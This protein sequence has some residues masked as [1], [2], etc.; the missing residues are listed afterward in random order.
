MKRERA[1]A[2][3]DTPIPFAVTFINGEPRGCDFVELKLIQIFYFVFKTNMQKS[4]VV[5]IDV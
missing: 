4:Q 3:V 1:G 5:K 2:V